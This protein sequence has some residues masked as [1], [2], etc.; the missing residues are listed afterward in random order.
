MADGTASLRFN[1]GRHLGT[2]WID[3]V[4]IVSDR[5][6][7]PGF[8][9]GLAPWWNLRRGEVTRHSVGRAT[10]PGQPLHLLGPD[11][12]HLLYI[13]VYTRIPR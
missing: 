11:A 1:C 12:A 10:Q 5:L 3:D 8:E 7:N 4:S 6:E 2:V 9:A 13:R